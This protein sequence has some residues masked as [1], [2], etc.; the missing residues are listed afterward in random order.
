MS[1]LQKLIET[2]FKLCDLEQQGCI[3]YQDVDDV[4]KYLD[5]KRC[6]A[7][8]QNYLGCESANKCEE[9]CCASFDKNHDIVEQGMHSWLFKN[10]YLK[11]FKK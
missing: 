1:I 2:Y 8:C 6:C 10:Y 11:K 3:S 7:F 5:G 9:G 4:F